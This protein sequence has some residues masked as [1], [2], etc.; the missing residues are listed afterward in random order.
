MEGQGGG[1]A[2]EALGVG[3]GQFPVRLL[4]SVTV[5]RYV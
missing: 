3:M 5:Y 1:E 4:I 2:R